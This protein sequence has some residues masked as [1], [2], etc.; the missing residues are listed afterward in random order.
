M[1]NKTNLLKAL[2]TNPREAYDLA[3]NLGVAM[4]ANRVYEAVA[5]KP[6]QEQQKESKY[7]ILC[8][9]AHI[10]VGIISTLQKKT[11]LDII[12]S[13]MKTTEEKVEFVY[14]LDDFFNELYL[15]RE[16]EKKAE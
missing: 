13:Y 7:G 4:E 3:R 1:F 5:T 10:V 9:K 11:G 8:K 15:G 6:G 16:Y 12:K 2:M 14:A